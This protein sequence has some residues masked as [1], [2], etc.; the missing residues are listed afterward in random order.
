[1]KEKKRLNKKKSPL[2]VIVADM[3]HFSQTVSQI[4]SKQPQLDF[5]GA[6][7]VIAD[8]CSGI[9]EY[10]EN[11]VCLLL[12]KYRVCI[13]GCNLR[14]KCLSDNVVT[15]TGEIKGFEYF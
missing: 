6:H 13:F 3:K 2:S 7:T 5:M 11:K 4:I 8:C 14:L 10:S 12:E 15:V 1:M 9:L